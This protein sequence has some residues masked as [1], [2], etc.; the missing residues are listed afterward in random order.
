MTELFNPFVLDFIHKD[1]NR[2]VNKK[3][4]QEISSIYVKKEVSYASREFLDV[5][6]NFLSLLFKSKNIYLSQNL[7]I[8]ILY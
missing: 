3:L 4:M 5:C 7:F 2:S 1:L 6:I 8:I